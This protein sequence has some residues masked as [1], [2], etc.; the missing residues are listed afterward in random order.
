MTLFEVESKIKEIYIKLYG[1]K[2]IHKYAGILNVKY[3]FVASL[4]LRKYLL[5]ELKKLEILKESLI[6]PKVLD[7]E[8]DWCNVYFENNQIKIKY[9]NIF[10]EKY[11]FE[12][13]RSSFEV[14][15]PFII[16]KKLKPLKV[17]ICNNKIVSI[18][19][20]EEVLNIFS[21]L[22]LK[23]EYDLYLTEDK[24]ESF[25]KIKSQLNFIENKQIIEFYRII[26]HSEYLKYLCQIQ[27]KDY[28]II[29]A[30]ELIIS[31]K[32]IISEDDAFLFTINTKTKMFIIWE[33]ILINKATYI[34]E[35]N[36]I[37]YFE[38]L[39]SIFD[40]IVSDNNKKRFKLGALIKLNENKFN[41][42]YK[43]I[44]STKEEWIGKLQSI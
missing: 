19:N 20:L 31:N 24:S 11:F 12:F 41:L 6:N 21:I 8:V 9:G 5:E 26:E 4:H 28:K 18:S 40:F 42:V 14:L 13:A 35:T 44:H 33:S 7:L 16:N 2:G 3:K 32:Q 34:F 29:P 25:S 37:N 22:T 10:S 15:K 27:S 1:E 36:E 39:Q 17:Q 30:T 23:K 43:L 38:D